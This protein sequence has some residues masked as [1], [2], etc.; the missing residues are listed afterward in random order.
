MKTGDGSES[1][2]ANYGTLE[3]EKWENAEESEELWQVWMT[4]LY[5]IAKVTIYKLII[6]FR[7]KIEGFLNIFKLVELINLLGF[8]ERLLYERLKLL[9]IGCYN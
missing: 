2:K 3:N 5:L 8:A 6:K 4:Q 7:N 9:Y 1:E